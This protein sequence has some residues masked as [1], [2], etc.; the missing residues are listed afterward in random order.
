MSRDKKTATKSQKKKMKSI[1]ELITPSKKKATS[2]PEDDGGA[3][4]IKRAMLNLNQHMS[5]LEQRTAIPFETFLGELTANPPV[6]IRNVFQVFHDMM[7]AYVGEGLDEYSDDPESIH[8]VHYDCSKLFVDGTDHPFF[9]D[10]LFANR[11]ISLVEAWKRGA[12]QNKIYLFKGPPGC[13]K[14]TFLNN[15]LR[16]FEEYTNT[17][18]GLRYEAVWHFDRKI[19]G[20]LSDFENHPVLEKLSELLDTPLNEQADMLNEN[21]KTIDTKINSMKKGPGKALRPHK[22]IC[23][24]CKNAFSDTRKN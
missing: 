16:K 7:K 4:S 14:S 19:L 1:K 5:G 13:G 17:D 8:Y 18:A 24:N 12:Q 10:R 20:G 22:Y 15:L 3:E 6:V 2:I 21:K 9:A 23:I 11:L